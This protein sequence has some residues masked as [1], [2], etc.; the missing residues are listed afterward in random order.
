MS[1]GYTPTFFTGARALYF[2]LLLHFCRLIITTRISKN[3]VSPKNFWGIMEEKEGR[4]WAVSVLLSWGKGDDTRNSDRI[5]K[6]RPW[7]SAQP[8]S[9][10]YGTRPVGW[11]GNPNILSLGIPTSQ[12]RFLSIFSYRVHRQKHIQTIQTPEDRSH[13]C[14]SCTPPWA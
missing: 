12:F 6:P 13:N 4:D 7:R 2:A 8:V 10:C 11:D 3:N 5:R 14:H 9:K 1:N